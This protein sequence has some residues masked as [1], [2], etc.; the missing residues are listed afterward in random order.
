[1]KTAAG[2]PIRRPWV[3]LYGEVETKSEL[4]RGCTRRKVSLFGDDQK[5]S[6]YGDIAVLTEIVQHR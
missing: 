5:V 2:E 6:F 4:L 1:M 3:R